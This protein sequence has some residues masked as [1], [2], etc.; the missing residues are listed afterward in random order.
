M[1]TSD[2]SK[3]VRCSKTERKNTKTT[4]SDLNT[5]TNNFLPF[6]IEEL[7]STELQNAFEKKIYTLVAWVSHYHPQYT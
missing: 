4:Y 3:Y 7:N 1:R 2:S 6:E 5:I